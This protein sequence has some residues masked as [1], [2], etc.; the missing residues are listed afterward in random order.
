[1]K[2]S[3]LLPIVLLIFLSGIFNSLSAQMKSDKVNAEIT[4]ALKLWNTAT[5]N[6]NTDQAIALFDISD[7]IMVIGSDSGEVFKG[8]NQISG[9]LNAIFKH[10][11]FSW[12]MNRTDIDYNENTAWIFM[13]GSMIVT[14]DKGKIRKTPY[15]FTGIMVRKKG[16]WKWRLFDGSIPK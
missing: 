10:N 12:E 8:K 4:E 14:N 11:S 16:E 3:I 5:K 1:M 9:W 6:A 2:K 15:R 13:D 7:N